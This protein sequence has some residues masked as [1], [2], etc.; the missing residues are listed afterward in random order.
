MGKFGREF[1]RDKGTISR[2]E[3]GK[4]AVPDGMKACLEMLLGIRLV[5]IVSKH[6]NDKF[7]AESFMMDTLEGHAR[8][9]SRGLVLQFSRHITMRV[10]PEYLK[11]NYIYSIFFNWARGLVHAPSA[12]VRAHEEVLYPRHRKAFV[13][14]IGRDGPSM[15]NIMMRSD[16]ERPLLLAREYEDWTPDQVCRL[17][18]SMSRESGPGRLRFVLIDDTPGDRDDREPIMDLLDSYETMAVV[19]D[20]LTVSRI[21]GDRKVLW[22]VAPSLVAEN[23]EM[24]RRLLPASIDPEQRGEDELRRRSED[25]LRRCHDIAKALLKRRASSCKRDA[26]RQYARAMLEDYPH[27]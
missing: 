14:G 7:D 5:A 11:N 20:Y 22:S 24:L 6:I 16:Y 13:D 19:G 8:I 21:K 15:V 4:D 1:A 3:S 12:L 18:E 10:I 17:F 25:E 27:S 9:G 26:W 2:W 23:A